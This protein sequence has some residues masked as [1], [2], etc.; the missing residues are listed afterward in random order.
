MPSDLLTLK[1]LAAELDKLLAGGKVQKITQPEKDEVRFVVRSGANFTLVASANPNAPR[2]HITDDKKENPYAAPSFCMLLRKHL[3]GATLTGIRT[4]NDDRIIAVGFLNRT[5]LFDIKPFTLFVELMGRYSNLILCDENNKILDCMVK[6]GF[7]ADAR[8]ILMPNVTYSAP[9]KGGKA[10]LYQPE[11]IAELL[12]KSTEQNP[13]KAV[14]QCVNGLSKQTA[15]EVVFRSSLVNPYAEERVNSA[16]L[17]IT[18]LNDLTA[19]NGLKPC[20]LPDYS[21]F[22]VIPYISIKPEDE[23]KF[24]PTLNGAVNACFTLADNKIRK[25]NYG[26]EIITLVKRHRDKLIKKIAIAEEKLAE[27]EGMENVRIM[28]ELLTA[29]IYKVKRGDKSVI[30]ENYYDEM[31]PLTIPLDGAKSPQQNAAQLFNKFN[32]LKR[33]KVITAEQLAQNT[34]ELNYTLSILDA[35]S[36]AEIADIEE[37]KEELYSLKILKKPQTRRTDKTPAKAQPKSFV[38][39][40]GHTVYV[41]TNNVMNNEVTFKIGRSYDIWL[42]VK[43]H[44]GSHIII[45]KN[46]EN[47]VISDDNLL[48][49]AQTAAFFSEAAAGDNVPVDYTER[50]NVRR[51]KDA[52]LGMVNYDNYKTLFVTPKNNIK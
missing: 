24:F 7:D 31:R 52:G 41:G 5:E 2:L 48:L 12:S 17:E 36:R 29:N 33:A 10:E 13:V 25:D 20:T 28:A 40:D 4:F 50:R 45:R 49:A 22:F 35:L 16:V 38:T 42:H 14:M 15:A 6:I 39:P 9:D 19:E 18:K 34:A 47:E 26:K 11:K 3:T 44:H 23:Y 27:C 32:K 43:N 46:D 21:D 1:I 30:V 51:I 8:R 37:I